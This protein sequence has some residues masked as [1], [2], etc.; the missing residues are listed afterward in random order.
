MDFI[1]LSLFSLFYRRLAPRMNIFHE[2]KA[3]LLPISIVYDQDALDGLSNLFN[4]ESAF[5]AVSCLVQLET[6]F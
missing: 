3:A 6:P 1:L 4:A 5:D 2:V